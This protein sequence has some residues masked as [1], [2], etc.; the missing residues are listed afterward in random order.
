M[1]EVEV[2]GLIGW[3]GLWA[4]AVRRGEPAPRSNAIPFD[5]LD[6]QCA[7]WAESGRLTLRVA[8]LRAV[9]R[10]LVPESWG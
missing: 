8:L 10:P 3:A 2:P 6:P 1:R 7:G 4:D 5:H 9:N